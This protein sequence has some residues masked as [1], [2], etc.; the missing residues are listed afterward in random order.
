MLEGLSPS[1]AM[2]IA[3]IR[4]RSGNAAFEPR[5]VRGVLFDYFDGGVAPQPV[6]GIHTSPQ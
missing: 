1:I 2:T 4:S 5:E 6:K 3:C